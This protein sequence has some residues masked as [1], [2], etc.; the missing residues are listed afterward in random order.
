[1]RNL[2]VE[3]D[4]F[5][6]SSTIMKRLA[7]LFTV[8]SAFAGVIAYAETPKLGTSRVPVVFSGGHETDPQDRGRPVKL[9]AAGLGV[10]TD[11]FREAFSQ[12]RPAHGGAPPAPE[13]VREN[14]KALMSAL[15]KYG[16]TNERL[17]EVSNYY[18]YVRER[19][20]LW[21]NKPAK[22][23]AIVQN[24]V[25][26]NFEIIDGGAGYSSAPNVS[27]PNVKMDSA[28]VELAFGKDLK[29]NGSVSAITLTTA[30]D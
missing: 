5:K 4:R 11:V 14:K 29:K 30:K 3:D 22:A 21:T 28:K 25:V 8:F 7:F 15:R 1:M 2:V 16:V 18:R 6:P 12:V 13:Q 27:V 9:V 26:T 23:M 19:D 17:D 20:E 24:G 10:P